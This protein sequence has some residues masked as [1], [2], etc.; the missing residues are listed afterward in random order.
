MASRY[1]LL[2]SAALAA[3][4]LVR[5]PRLS[6]GLMLGGVVLFCGPNYY[7]ALSGQPAYSGLTPLGGVLL[8]L[9]WLSAML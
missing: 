2:H 7:H 4:P 3:V 6:G 8:V 1:H 5:H 9:A